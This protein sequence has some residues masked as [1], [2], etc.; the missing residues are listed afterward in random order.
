MEEK[1][2]CETTCTTE[3]SNGIVFELV[4]PFSTGEFCYSTCCDAPGIRISE[5]YAA[6]K[7]LLKYFKWCHKGHKI[8]YRCGVCDFTGSGQVPLLQAKTQQGKNHV[9]TTT[10]PGELR[11]M[12]AAD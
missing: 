4:F 3:G 12:P 5:V 2:P 10:G 9:A 11:L 7:D 8:I 1:A 6:H